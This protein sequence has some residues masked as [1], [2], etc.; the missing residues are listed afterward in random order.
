[1]RQF[2]A[3]A[4]LAAV[5]L[6]AFQPAR[7]FAQ[8]SVV[9]LG[10]NLSAAQR[11]TMRQTFNRPGARTIIIRHQDEE[12]LLAGIAPQSEIG[13]RSISSSA[14]T[15]KPAGTGIQVRT[16]HITWVT[17]LMY[18]NALATA[19][20][21]DAQVEVD[22]PFPVS[23]TAALAGILTAYQTA[24]GSR[25]GLG[26]QQTAAR[27]MVVTG[28]LG[29]QIGNKAKASALIMNVK[30][31]VIGGHLTSAAAIRPVVVAEAHRLSITL[32]RTQ[33]D[34][35]IHLM[36]AISRLPLNPATV[37]VQ[38]RGWQN[39]A[40]GVLPLGVWPQ[41]LRWLRVIWD[42]VRSLVRGAI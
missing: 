6:L 8:N 22:A 36:V 16:H 18:A 13:A 40:A 9:T 12:R 1:M 42:A 19:G 15:I 27:E 33:I 3:F 35:I 11:Q 28:N 5:A 29:D 26:Q 21:K 32:N 30:S 34:G 31:R 38:L 20:V 37:A 14:V 7:A 17:P 23:G 4:V 24:S 10:G 41:I 2:H 39:Q 25:I